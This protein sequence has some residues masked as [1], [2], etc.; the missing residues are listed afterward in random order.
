M[1]LTSPAFSS[2]PAREGVPEKR[3][4]ALKAVYALPASINWKFGWDFPGV[5][6][7]SL[8]LVGL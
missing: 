2:E 6:F 1:G 3:R 5:L 7:V 8:S 4:K